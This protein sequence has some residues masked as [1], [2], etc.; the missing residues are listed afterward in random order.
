MTLIN[1]SG[2][3]NGARIREKNQ[4]ERW[5]ICRWLRW[6]KRRED[7]R[8]EPGW[9]L[10]YLPMTQ[11]GKTARGYAKRTRV[12]VGASADDSGGKNGARIREKNQG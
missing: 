9:T 3:K 4:G 7:T 8:K 6:E 10:A 1:D 5:R 11:V 12:K 2:G